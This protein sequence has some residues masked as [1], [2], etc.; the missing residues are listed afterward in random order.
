M[1]EMQSQIRNWEP[2]RELGPS[3]AYKDLKSM[4][5]KLRGAAS[6]PEESLSILEKAKSLAKDLGQKI[7]N[8][9]KSRECDSTTFAKGLIR[10][11][12][13]ARKG[14]ENA[15]TSL[16]KAAGK[17][18]DQNAED[19]KAETNDIVMLDHDKD[20]I[21]QDDI[22]LPQDR[23]DDGYYFVILDNIALEKFLGSTFFHLCKVMKEVET[24]KEQNLA[25]AEEHATAHQYPCPKVGCIKSQIP[26]KRKGN[27]DNHMRK[28]HP[29]YETDF[30]RRKLDGSRVGSGSRA[31]SIDDEDVNMVEAE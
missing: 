15:A 6:L 25:Q 12:E 11:V 10:E 7:T 23:R 28:E 24:A 16:Y 17:R 27:L 20:N 8:S 30:K 18:E 13:Q 5:D 22:P 9:A 3:K 19:Q 26:Y 1:V 2:C 31:G 29:G 4:V 14:L 21:P